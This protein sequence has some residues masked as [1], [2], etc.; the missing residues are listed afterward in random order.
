M[1]IFN[2]SERGIEKTHKSSYKSV[3]R[4]DANLTPEK[5]T[6]G[7]KLSPHKKHK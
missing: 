6:P 3:L 4:Q 7:I 1:Y 5:G 2:F